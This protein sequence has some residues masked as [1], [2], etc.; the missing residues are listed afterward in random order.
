MTRLI[1]ISFLALAFGVWGLGCSAPVVRQEAQMPPMP[2]AQ[3]QPLSTTMHHGFMIVTNG[4][5]YIYDWQGNYMET[6]CP[7][8]APAPRPHFAWSNGPAG[9]NLWM[10]Q[11]GTR[12]DNMK[13]QYVIHMSD[14]NFWPV[15]TNQSGYIRFRL[16]GSI[17]K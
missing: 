8:P 11:Y 12:P 4:C 13:D 6:V 16:F 2:M 10:L 1:I 5:A 7:Y 3:V 14:T 17:G 15:Q 9:T